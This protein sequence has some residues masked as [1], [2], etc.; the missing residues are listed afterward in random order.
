[1]P[2]AAEVLIDQTFRA[3]ADP[4]RRSIIVR[5]SRGPAAREHGTGKLLDALA[6]FLAG[7]RVR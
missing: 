7:E 5:L 6:R 1:V 3:F 4:S 2:V